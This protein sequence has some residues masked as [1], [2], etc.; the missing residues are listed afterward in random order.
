MYNLKLKN[1]KGISLISLLVIIAIIVIAVILI[2]SITKQPGYK[3]DIDNSE[4]IAYFSL[5]VSIL[6]AQVSDNL[7]NTLSRE[8]FDTLGNIVK[9]ADSNNQWFTDADSKLFVFANSADDDAMIDY[10]IPAEDVDKFEITWISDGRYCAFFV[11]KIV[12]ED[13][14]LVDY[15]FSADDVLGCM[16]TIE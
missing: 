3:L 9:N 5:R 14:Y 10:G 13:Y 16:L 6:G 12:G 15:D 8:Y 1:Q 11:M 7:T 4:F 2:Y